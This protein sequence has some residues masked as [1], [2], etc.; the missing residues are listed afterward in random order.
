MSQPV[1]LSDR[2]VLEARLTGQI[3]ERSIAGQVEYWARLG[4]ITDK[5][6]GGGRPE[7]ALRRAVSIE[8]ILEIA[9]SVDTPEGRRR[10]AEYLQSLPY[11]HFEGDP[12]RRDLLIKID[13][14]GT[15]TR[16]RFVDREF[17]AV[18]TRAAKAKQK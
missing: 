2:L 5:A 14:D 18:G 3:M 11:P 4:Q 13:A 15:R 7:R 16:G 1:K 9:A 6:M 10:G 17:R 8:S 12:K